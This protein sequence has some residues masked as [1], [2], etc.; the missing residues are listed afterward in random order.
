LSPPYASTPAP[1]IPL[2]ATEA[3]FWSVVEEVAGDINIHPGSES[4]FRE[5]IRAGLKKM[6]QEK[7]DTAADLFAAR[8]ALATFVLEVKKEARTRGHPEWLGEDSTMG[9]AKRLLKMGIRLWPF[10]P[11]PWSTS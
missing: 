5:M 4:M 2:K 8:G 7:R 11:P 3:S 9:A 1:G 10:L 6:R